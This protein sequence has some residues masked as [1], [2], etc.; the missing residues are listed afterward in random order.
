M[1]D[2]NSTNLTVKPVIINYLE[3]NLA[4]FAQ[5]I[6]LGGDVKTS[7]GAA[8]S[9]SCTQFSLQ[10]LAM[11]TGVSLDLCRAVCLEIIQDSKMKFE[12]H[13]LWVV[14]QTD[15]D[16]ANKRKI[17]KHN[18]FNEEDMGGESVKVDLWGIDLSVTGQELKQHTR[19]RLIWLQIINDKSMMDQ[20]RVDNVVAN[21]YLR[22]HELV[23]GVPI[24]HELCSKVR[25]EPC[26][27]RLPSKISDILTKQSEP[28]SLVESQPHGSD[29]NTSSAGNT[30][31]QNTDE[32]FEETA[33][34]TTNIRGG[35]QSERGLKRPYEATNTPGT[36][37]SDGAAP[38][39]T[40]KTVLKR[41]LTPSAPTTANNH[42]LGEDSLLDM[43]LGPELVSRRNSSGAES[44]STSN[45]E[46]SMKKNFEL[47]KSSSRLMATPPPA[48]ELLD[49]RGKR[50]L[51]ESQ[52]H[53]AGAIGGGNNKLLDGGAV[54]SKKG[55]KFGGEVTATKENARPGAGS[56]VFGDKSNSSG[57]GCPKK[58]A[59]SSFSGPKK[60]GASSAGNL[61]AYFKK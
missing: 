19:G 6:K 40:G 18:D 37:G 34:T 55:Y 4:S 24:S 17:V 31:P 61:F 35:I 9:S 21:G 33:A 38:G 50:T 48:A 53:S 54:R 59:T 26:G 39:R 58:A 56:A 57:A 22:W 44:S 42:T 27:F 8:L 13:P 16:G 41:K 29:N 32:V 23:K 20:K 12:V 14:N 5:A 1:N 2:N 60:K 15:V 25:E 45:I 46:D 47:Q 28:P 11:N 30:P 51:D 3:E 43:P 49:N 52:Q 36:G 10:G 7:G